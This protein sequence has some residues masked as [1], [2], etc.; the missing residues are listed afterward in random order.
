MGKRTPWLRALCYPLSETSVVTRPG[1]VRS[2][3][4]AHLSRGA[5]SGPPQVRL[6]D[7]HLGGV[8]LTTP[9]QAVEGGTIEAEDNLLWWD[10]NDEVGGTQV[11]G[12]TVAPYLVPRSNRML[13]TLFEV[14]GTLDPLPL[15]WGVVEGGD[16]HKI[17]REVGETGTLTPLEANYWETCQPDAEP[18]T[19]AIAWRGTDRQEQY[20]AETTLP[21]PA[22][23]SWAL[24]LWWLGTAP[25]FRDAEPATIE[26]P[27][28]NVTVDLSDEVVPFVDVIWGGGTWAV[29]FALYE[30]PVL[31]RWL[32]GEWRRVRV[33]DD[34]DGDLFS[35][36]APMWLRVFLIA[37][38][39][40]VQV[41]TAGGH[42]AQIVHTETAPDAFGQP[43]V[44]PVRVGPGPMRLHGRGVA[45]SA[46]L[47]EYRFGRWVPEE[48]SEWGLVT[49]AHFDGEGSFKRTYW[50][51]RS[52]DE[53]AL[54]A[55]AFGHY[56]GGEP[57]PTPGLSEGNAA[58]V[59]TVVDEAVYETVGHASRR[60]G[61]RRYTCTLEAHNPELTREMLEEDGHP[62]AMAGARTPFVYAVAVR[63]G[64]SRVSTSTDPVDLRPAIT[65]ATE[66]LADPALSAGPSWQ[67]EINR[68]LLSECI[69]QG[70]GNPVGASWSDYVDKYHR[71]DIDLS[72]Q[73]ADGTLHAGA[74][75]W[76]GTPAPY[77][78][79]LIG[80]IMG[81]SASTSRF[82]DYSGT[83]T[84]R[85]FSVLLQAPAGII[86]SR[87][88][89][90][91]LLLHEKL[92]GGAGRR[93]MG[94]E[95]VQ[96]IIA[97]AI[98]PEVA[99]TLVHE[100]ADD[101]YDLLTHRMLLD[102]PAGGFL[103]PP[104]FGSDARQWI[105]QFARRDLA[106]HFWAAEHGSSTNVVPY[107]SNYYE[108]LAGAPEVDV[109]DAVVAGATDN[110]LTGA[111]WS[112]DAAQDYNR[113]LVQG[114]PP[115]QAG[116]GGLM[117]AL[118]SMSAEA[119]I[120]SGSPISSQNI[121]QTWERTKLLSGNEY[122]L[123][124]TGRV[125]AMNLLRL[126]RGVDMR[127]ITLVVRGNPYLWWGWKVIPHMDAAASD[128]HGLSLDGQ[129]TRVV[130]ITNSIDFERGRFETR[131]RVPPEPEA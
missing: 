86:D 124:N 76:G 29:H 45:F 128:P 11:S 100:F 23:Q 49:P 91:D 64:S 26:T 36:H 121:D 72:W 105:E 22:G 67:L 106:V 62:E 44:A 129:R 73:N 63:V 90:L 71:I 52:V 112:H 114:S 53:T 111:D 7:Q 43:Q 88:A 8:T 102:P 122:W 78:R 98:S 94:W 39:L 3:L 13:D 31:C 83:I 79:R 115:G 96:E 54:S 93:L 34:F 95:A 37:G 92:R 40:V 103:F 18:Q 117:P 127:G 5:G 125:V 74:P 66:D 1:F 77:V 99:A 60:S 27:A 85:D 21:L 108:H 30:A 87:Y 119:R 65:A 97:R 6:A 46:Q 82:G 24:R 42:T 4:L 12:Y 14:V 48:V 107:Y 10:L 9:Q 84:C 38:R 89:P 61:R 41:E 33:F 19:E 101:H 131:L 15:D 56:A 47:H 28:G 123:G 50:C 2:D 35:D 51:N 104:P 59:G 69:H 70:T 75:P 55:T 17:M 109:Y 116:M 110:L 58:G 118:P 120:E 113:V 57:T 68:S 81:R 130:R 20:A 80:F 16:L 126:V 25:I 32:N